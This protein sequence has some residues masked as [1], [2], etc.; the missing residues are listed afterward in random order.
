M[1]NLK[2]FFSALTV[3]FA[4]LS[5]TKAMPTDISMSITFICLAVTMLINSK[6][7]INK[8]QKKTAVY[9]LVLGVFLLII[10]AYN[11]ASLIWKI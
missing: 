1:N 2:L 10:T 11:I 8:K 3:S 5:L 6:D 7:C 4:I 9:F